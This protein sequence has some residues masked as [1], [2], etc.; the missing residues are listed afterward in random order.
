MVPVVMVIILYHGHMPVQLEL[1]LQVDPHLVLIVQL[2]LIL[3]HLPQH[4]HQHVLLVQ[5]DTGL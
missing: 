1:I 4:L 3:L 5:M 2:E